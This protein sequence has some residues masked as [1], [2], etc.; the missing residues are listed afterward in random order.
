MIIM[1]ECKMFTC[2]QCKMQLN[3]TENLC[4]FCDFDLSKAK[5]AYRSA[6]LGNPEAQM[7]LSAMYKFGMYVECNQQKYVEW[8]LKAAKN[9][10]VTSMVEMGGYFYDAA[11][12][13]Q[14]ESL[15]IRALYWLTE[16]R[17]HG[18]VEASNFLNQLGIIDAIFVGPADNPSLIELKYK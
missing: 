10:D 11:Q 13:Q 15:L 5:W 17:N 9:G 2:P 14:D 18:D 12:D 16:A 7:R 8:A 3:G 6:P 4:P 1:E